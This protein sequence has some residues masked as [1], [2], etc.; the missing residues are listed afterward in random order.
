[1]MLALNIAG[2]MADLVARVARDRDRSAFAALFDYYVPRLASY[3][4]RLGAAANAPQL[5]GIFFILTGD[6]R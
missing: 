2:D 3:L 4:H 1:M 6:P 5:L